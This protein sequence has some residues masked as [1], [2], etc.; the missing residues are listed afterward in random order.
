[1]N[2]LFDL[3]DHFY[4][5]LGGRHWIFNQL[6]VQELRELLAA[7]SGAE[8]A[9]SGLIEIIAG[10]LRGP[11]CQMD[12]FS[13]EAM[14]APRVN[15]E[16]ARRHYL[17][18]EWSSCALLLM[19]VMDGFVNDVEPAERR[20]LHTRDPQ[21]MVAWDSLV[22]HHKGLT[23]VMPIFRK[24]FKRRHDDEVFEVHRQ[25]GSDSAGR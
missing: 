17:A 14:R 6:P 16:R 8:E 25:A 22:G 4:E 11:R 1:M 7:T 13:H 10:R 3:V 2:D 12:L 20:G 24:T 21:E 5:V 19:T 18:Q 23:A 15:I 9:E